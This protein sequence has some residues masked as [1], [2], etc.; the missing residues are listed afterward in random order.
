M[1]V[2]AE[3]VRV[4]VDLRQGDTERA[5][6][7]D[8]PLEEYGPG[9]FYG[10][11]RDPL[12]IVEFPDTG[13]EYRGRCSRA[14]RENAN[15]AHRLGYRHETIDRADWTDDLYEIRASAPV[16][17]GRAMPAAYLRR[18]EYP[19]DPEPDCAHHGYTVHGVI[20]P[21][22]RLAGYAQIVQCGEMAR[23]NT[24]IGHADRL[25]DRVM[26]LLMLEAFRWH[27]DRCGA[28][29]GLYYTHDSGHGDG[30]R[31]WK[32]RFG[33]RPTDATWGFA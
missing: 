22:E 21:D 32:E 8:L 31:Y 10:D 24:I 16:R 15:Y 13:D 19:H 17:Q 18:Q 28:R 3:L 7:R 4:T 1:T 20:G 27:I 26:W 5:V 30:L 2:V 25:R 6:C 12:A 11:C 29:F 14:V 23:L 9:S 33:M